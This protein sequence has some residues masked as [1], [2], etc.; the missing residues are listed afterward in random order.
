MKSGKKRVITVM[1]VAAVIFAALAGIAVA[2][3]L[4]S[5]ADSGIVDTGVRVRDPYVLEHDGVYYMYG[6]G[7]AKQ[8][9]G[10]VYS[11]DL[12]E[13]SEPVKVCDTAGQCDAQDNWWAPE[14]HFYNGAF[15][16]FATYRS[17]ATGKRGVGIFR[18]PD[19]LGP[20]EL[21]TGGHITPKDLDSI[22]GTLYVDEDGQPWMIY[23]GEWT[24]NEDGVGDMMAAKLSADLTSF[25]SEPVLL[26]RATDMKKRKS[27]VTDGPFLYKTENGRLI[28][29][30]SNNDRGGYSVQIAYSTD[31]RPDGEWK[32]QQP[33]L[34]SKT[35]RHG[36]GGHGM[37]FT[38]PDGTLTLSIHS[39]NN[40]TEND[41]T[42]ALL[43]PVA[44]TGD[45]LVTRENDN[46]LTR[47][48]FRLYYK[49][50]GSG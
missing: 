17:A 24:S 49:L 6:T 38:A 48:Y 11:T 12:R 23:V 34:F 47:L 46:F 35:K 10:C 8:G 16:L 41:P 43:V 21:I 18:S 20:F 9:Y 2:A 50:K 5:A 3:V 29:L 13:W 15:Y 42:T 27:N 28:M 33:S 19:P 39:P 26:F 36:D 40:A 1:T 25:V 14:C 45:T 30:W 32:Q 31:G 22:D 7:L 44:D 4:G 37:L